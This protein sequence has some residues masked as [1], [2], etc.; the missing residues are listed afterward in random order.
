MDATDLIRRLHQHRSWVN[1][2]LLG[3]AAQLTD[4]QL[5]ATYPIGQGSIWKSL[6]HLHGAEFVWLETLLGD[7]S[8][9]LPGDLPRMIPG[10]QQGEAPIASLDELRQKWQALDLRWSGYLDSL[11]PAS[12][13][14]LV[15]K[16]I[17]LTG[18]RF[19]TRRGDILL[20][21]CTHSQYTTAQIMNMLRQVGV[22]QF[23]EVMLIALAR[24][25]SV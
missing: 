1:I 4:V 16:V 24:L 9:L 13:D 21:V 19:V 20:H 14:D 17:S 5:R 15:P 23:P 22:T 6:L 12:L 10:N 18:Q 8:P 7:E 25:E 3:A 11:N 2:N